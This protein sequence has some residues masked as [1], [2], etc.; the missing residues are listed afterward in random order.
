MDYIVAGIT[1]TN[2]VV[3]ADGTKSDCHL[4]GAIFALDGVRL[5]TDNVLY[6]SNVGPDFEKYYGQWMDDNNLKRD[7]LSDVLEHTHYNIVKYYPD[8]QYYEYSIYGEEFSKRN[9]EKT[10]ITGEQILAVCKGAKAMYLDCHESEP[11]M[12]HLGDIRATGCKIM[13][14]P[15]S[16]MLIKP[17]LRQKAWEIIDQ[18]DM[19]TMN[20]PESFA[21]FGVETE[22]EV[23][24]KLLAYGKPCFYRV[25]S[26]GSYMVADGKY[27]FA[28]SID[29]GEFVDQTGC[30]NCSTAA[31]MYAWFEGNDH[32]MTCIMSNLAAAYNL[33]QYGPYPKT[34]AETS[35]H[36]MELAHKYYDEL[37]DK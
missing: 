32:L 18:V 1:I 21:L 37:K 33:L 19:Y 24:E 20:K 15:P 14:E 16:N 2:D 29:V 4:G 17:E 28:P 5:F 9:R 35:A 8:G 3:F 27:A 22:E 13:W 7:G 23:L 25:G 6:V 30:G 10:D 12:A 26:K 11:V 36:I 34:T 31:S